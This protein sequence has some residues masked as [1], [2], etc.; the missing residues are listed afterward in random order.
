MMKKKELDI[1]D[2]LEPA[3]I[4]IKEYS[5]QTA[6]F[7]S[8]TWVDSGDYTI[9]EIARVLPNQ[10]S[11]IYALLYEFP[12]LLPSE[13]CSPGR[14][15]ELI[16]L[17]VMERLRNKTKRDYILERKIKQLWTENGGIVP[18]KLKRGR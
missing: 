7:T 2:I 6:P 8:D 10:L 5:N 4:H 14:I 12:H 11:F 3:T 18:A 13:K 16:F 17:D 15:Q 9:H 1:F